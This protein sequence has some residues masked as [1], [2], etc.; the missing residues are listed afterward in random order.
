MQ[1]HLSELHNKCLFTKDLEVVKEVVDHLPASKV[2]EVEEGRITKEG[3]LKEPE[4]VMRPGRHHLSKG[5][6]EDKVV[7]CRG[8]GL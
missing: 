6:V 4:D 8:K 3:G 1:R 2:R 7:K 5:G